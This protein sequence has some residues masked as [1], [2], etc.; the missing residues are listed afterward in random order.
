VA[1]RERLLLVAG[2]QLDPNVGILLRRTLA[3]GVPFRAILVGPELVPTVR[4]RLDDAAFTLDGERIRPTTCFIRHD[5]FLADGTKDPTAST[6]ALN[7]YHAIKGWVLAHPRVRLFNRAA[8]ADTSKLENLALA[9]RAGLR[10]PDTWIGNELRCDEV[11]DLGPAIIKP[12]AGG[13]LTELLSE[14]KRRTLD[15]AGVGRYPRMVQRRLLR[16][17]LRVFRVGARLLGFSLESPD[18][19]YRSK[20]RVRL[21]PAKVPS[22]VAAGLVRLCNRIGLD[23]A[24]ADFMRAP[25]N[26]R[27]VFLEVNSQPMFAAF[28]L[29]AGGKLCDAILDHLTAR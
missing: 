25:G 20:Q 18:V 1:G 7:W 9:R 12:P 2:G 10:I 27:L 26:G 28:D 22:D 29:A 3:R 11:R 19:D 15:G 16:P 6:A 13:E 23:F 17:E 5:V 8:S 4:M 14:R 24:A 21:R